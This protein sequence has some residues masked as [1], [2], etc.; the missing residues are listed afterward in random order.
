MKVTK[1]Y[2]NFETQQLE[3]RLKGVSIVPLPVLMAVAYRRSRA[4]YDPFDT[5]KNGA[6]YFSL[7]ALVTKHIPTIHAID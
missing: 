6:L 7:M 4:L 5:H 1:C 3:M 2:K